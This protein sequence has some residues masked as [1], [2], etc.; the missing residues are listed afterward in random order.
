ME[1]LS[2]VPEDIKVYFKEKPKQL[3][4]TSGDVKEG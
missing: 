3:P 2:E 1:D 4:S